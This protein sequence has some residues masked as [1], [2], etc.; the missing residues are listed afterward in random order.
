MARPRLPAVLAGALLLLAFWPGALW[1]EITGADGALLYAR[2]VRPGERIALSYL[3]SVTKR[4]VEETWEVSPRAL[5]ILRETAF[6][7]FGAGLPAEPGPG[8][9]LALERGKIRL[10]GMRRELP[11]LRLAVG[12]TADHTL[13]FGREDLAL[14]ALAE[15]G[16][17]L[18]LD[19]RRRPWWRSLYRRIRT[20]RGYGWR[21]Q[22]MKEQDSG[23]EEEEIDG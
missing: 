2:S 21:S 20:P 18:R 23:R 17:C 9:R 5:L 14:R 6:D 16:A 8:E 3:H 10:T 12:Q 13:R 7:T 4:P 1:F 22:G 11:G 15:P 19:V